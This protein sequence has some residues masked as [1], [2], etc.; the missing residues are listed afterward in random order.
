[1][2]EIHEE[3]QG[4]SPLARGLLREVEA[5]RV[6]DRIIPAR[7]GFTTPGRCRSGRCAD[8]P[9]SRGVYKWGVP[10]PRA[11]AGSSPLA[12]GLRRL[13][14]ARAPHLGIIPAR[15]GFTHPHGNRH[16]ESGDHPRSRGVYAAATALMAA[17]SGSSPLARGLH[18]PRSRNTFTEAYSWGCLGC[19]KG[20]C[21]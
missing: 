6:T 3:I 4:S 20:V 14:A 1:M 16:P 5:S 18:S 17:A 19:L 9:R 7:A 12:R 21:R 10:R 13:L 15:A 2:T 8:H 11:V